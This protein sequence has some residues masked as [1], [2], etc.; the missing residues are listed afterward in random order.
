MRHTTAAQRLLPVPA[1]CMHITK[2]SKRG[3]PSLVK[4]ISTCPTLVKYSKPVW[5][6]LTHSRTARHVFEEKTIRKSSGFIFGTAKKVAAVIFSHSRQIKLNNENFETVTT[7]ETFYSNDRIEK[8]S[9]LQ[10]FTSH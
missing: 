5:H 1:G 3:P 6:T 8:L 10:S 9:L 2:K 7:V 4:I